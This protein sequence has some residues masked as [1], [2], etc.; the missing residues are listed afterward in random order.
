MYRE[1]A[2][3]FYTSCGFIPLKDKD[4]S[5][6]N[7]SLLPKEL[8]SCVNKNVFLD[9]SDV[10]SHLLVLKPG[11]LQAQSSRFAEDDSSDGCN[12]VVSVS[13]GEGDEKAVDYFWCK[14]P[15][16][17]FSI[18]TTGEKLTFLTEDVQQCFVGLDLL[19]QIIP[20]TD[21]KLLP[22][23]AA[24]SQTEKRSF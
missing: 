24:H 8:Q 5:S 13:S 17:R 22:P 19:D 6:N 2:F 9:Y 11:T 10:S 12:S 23:G 1:T 15:S 20:T 3:Q 16:S 18:T 21:G 14:Y 7:F 4:K